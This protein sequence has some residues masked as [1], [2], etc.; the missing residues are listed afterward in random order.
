MKKAKLLYSKEDGF[1]KKEIEATAIT[2]RADAR[3]I[4]PFADENNKKVLWVNWGQHKETGKY[5]FPY[6]RHYPKSYK[7][8]SEI[9][10]EIKK[11]FSASLESK[12]HK[13][14]KECIAG[15]LEKRLKNKHHLPW[16]F[17]DT[18]TSDFPLSGDLLADVEVIEKE[19]I[20]RTPFGE[21]YRL[22]IALL[23][24]K[25]K[26]KRV[27]LAGIEIEFTHEFEM[28][29]CLLLKTLGFPLISIDVTSIDVSDI[30]EEWAD[31]SL[32]ETTKSNSSGIRK[33]YI[34]I[35]E[36]IYPLYMDIP[37]DILNETRHQ[38]LLF[39]KEEQHDRL[40]TYLSELKK[41]LSISNNDVLIQE[42]KISNEQTRKIVEH[43]GSIA[44][45]DWRNYNKDRFISVTLD[46]P[47]TKSG[48]IYIFHLV[49]AQLINAIF[50]TLVGYKYETGIKN[51]DPSILTWKLTD[52]KNSS[53]PN[54]K[55]YNLISKQVSEPI[56]K[57]I[58]L[59]NKLDK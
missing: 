49:M 17:K 3:K 46:K 23:G 5:I 58:E 39:I 7:H 50:D 37:R 33:N 20:L 14:A 55:I 36:S 18:R 31:K 32:I 47:L 34:Y 19:H 54:Y 16:A 11:R 26:N 12:N 30:S 1:L 10:I 2:S 59:F 44:G 21:E 57:I 27:L 53:Y 43:A 45:E 38:Y 52:Y 24:K 40:K 28:I 9:N 22:D 6:F 4:G 48:N 41:Y 35:H 29:K 25:V 51:Y 42:T 15:A 13:K 8:E 56:H